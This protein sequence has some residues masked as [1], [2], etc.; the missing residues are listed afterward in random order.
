M[1]QGSRGSRFG[2]GRLASS[3]KVSTG[4]RKSS[5]ESLMVPE[6]ETCIRLYFKQVNLK[7]IFLER[8]VGKEVKTG[9]KKFTQEVPKQSL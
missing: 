5:R 7:A 4:S 2:S 8:Q 1:G 9:G 6:Q 3:G